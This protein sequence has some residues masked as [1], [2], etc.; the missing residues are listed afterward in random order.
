[1][2]LFVVQLTDVGEPGLDARRDLLLLYLVEDISLQD[3]KIDI[4]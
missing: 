3:R 4:T 2:K 1:M